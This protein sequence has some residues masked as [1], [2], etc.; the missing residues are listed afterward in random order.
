[1]HSVDA[2]ENTPLTSGSINNPVGNAQLLSNVASIRHDVDPAVV[3]HY[4]VQRVIDLNCAVSGRDLGSA[5]SEVQKAI[6]G[7]GKLPAGT[8]ITI[9]GQSQAMR[10]SFRTLSGGIVLAIIP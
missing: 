8:L 3:D 1:M 4:S 5:T 2:I 9:R 6:D 7:L 10:D